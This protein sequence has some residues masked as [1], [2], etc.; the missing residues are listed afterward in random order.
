MQNKPAE[1]AHPG[2]SQRPST[3]G[4]RSVL[5]TD[6]RITGDITSDGTIEVTGEIDGTIT[7]RTLVIGSEGRVTGTVSAETIELRGKLEGRI[8]CQAL[9]LRAAATLR[10]DCTYAVL[11]IESGAHVEGRF[12]LAK[13]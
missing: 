13:P 8:S 5:A 3:Q 11:I 7:A 2:A 1:P 9:T 4:G 6:L 12:T 10:A